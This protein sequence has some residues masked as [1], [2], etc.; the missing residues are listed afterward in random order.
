MPVRIPS[1][2]LT[3]CWRTVDTPAVV[4]YNHPMDKRLLA[5]AIYPDIYHTIE[6]NVTASWMVCFTVCRCAKDVALQ[7]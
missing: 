2:N 3:H 6:S 7:L 4:S 1:T 5:A